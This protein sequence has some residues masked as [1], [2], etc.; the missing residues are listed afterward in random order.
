MS[1]ITLGYSYGQETPIE[2]HLAK[3]GLSPAWDRGKPTKGK[4]E[5]NLLRKGHIPNFEIDVVKIRSSELPKRVSEGVFDVA[6]VGTDVYM[7]HKLP[8]MRVVAKFDHGREIGQGN[9][10]LELV[11][12]PNSLI[13][14]IAEIPAGT[15]VMTERPHLTKDFLEKN[16]L[17][18]VLYWNTR[19]KVDFKKR[20]KASNRVGIEIIDG[21]GPQQIQEDELLALVTESGQTRED[22]DLKQIAIICDI[23]TLLIVN[24]Q[25]YNDPEKTQEIK[26]FTHKMELSYRAVETEGASDPIESF[27]PRIG[28]RER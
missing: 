17:K 10:Y 19:N 3:A 27:L 9:P 7:D 16:G 6:L 24:E 4:P 28:G 12:H 1:K 13:N 5:G 8:N 2:D 23:E 21:G 22:Y 11:A 18:T 26:N 14:S 15:V 25:S 20:L